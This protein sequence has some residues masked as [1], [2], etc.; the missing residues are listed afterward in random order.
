[1]LATRASADNFGGAQ[2]LPRV[3]TSD[4]P[5]RQSMLGAVPP[6][7]HEERSSRPAGLADRLRSW[8]GKY[9]LLVFTV[10]FVVIA[11][12]MII[13][14]IF[15][16]D[17]DFAT[18]GAKQLLEPLLIGVTW[19][20]L[21]S[22][23]ESRQIKHFGSG[24]TEYR[25]VIRGSF[26]A[27]GA[28]AIG[29][30]LFQAEVSRFYF[31]V[32]LPLGVGLLLAGRWACRVLLGV[33]RTSGRAL[34]RA[35]VIGRPGQIDEAVRDMTRH[36]EA[37]Y[38]PVAVCVMRADGGEPPETD[39]PQIAFKSLPDYMRLHEGAA[40]RAIGAVV[41]AGGL[42]RHT[43][44]RLSWGL[45]GDQ[46]ELLII[47]RIADVAG[48]R[49]HMRSV[50]GLGLMQVELPRYSGWNYH[51]KRAFDI[52]F[53]IVALVLLSPVFLAIAIAIKAD[54]PGPVLFRQERVGRGGR[55]FVIHK[56]RSMATDAEARLD[57]LRAK[58]IGNGAL[59]KMEHDPR[60]TR[61]GRV[62]RKLS[63][64]ELPQFWTVLRGDMSV[65]GPRPHLEKELA[66]FPDAGLRRLMIKP[67]ITGLWQVN[68]RSS[69]SLEES[70]RLDLSYVENWSLSGDVAIILR[71]VRAVLRRD[72]AH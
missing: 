25:R 41:V 47:P 15:R 68:G 18:V 36:P 3:P 4:V 57:A 65:V 23:T 24:L 28:V 43:T 66:E 55:P 70:V 39:L 37:G 64:D 7:P 22:I 1:M 45:D 17:A 13:S 59:F 71:T 60:V 58:S 52:V 26:Y 5:T 69:L 32:S 48:P 34:T 50:E 63:L 9:R 11:I 27:F 2:A 51:L 38:V 30:Y 31:V 49:L 72:G 19:F 61:V 29:S 14:H 46:A 12:V 56:F 33:L 20:G 6:V 10:D 67:G 53:A 40:G 44:R 54:D 21:L 8:G 62:L 16:F 42:S 35:I